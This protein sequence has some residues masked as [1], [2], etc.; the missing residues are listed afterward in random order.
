MTETQ[1]G[2]TTWAKHL[3]HD[4]LFEPLIGTLEGRV[5][6]IRQNKDP[7]EV[8][9][10]L[11]LMRVLTSEEAA[12][13]PQAL[14]Q[15]RTAYDQARTAYDQAR[16]AYAQAVY[17]RAAYAQAVYDEPR[18]VYD[19]ARTAYDR[20]RTAYDEAQAAYASDLEVLHARLCLK[21]CPWN[22]RTIFP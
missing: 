8:K 22:G 2:S 3:H 18:A 20:A 6:Y 9:T 12:Q 14:R 4:V 10:R 7:A 17:A 5:E 21:D 15:A 16:T 11:R 19:E 13:L 1:S